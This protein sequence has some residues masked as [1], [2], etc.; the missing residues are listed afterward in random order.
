MAFEEICAYATGLLAPKMLRTLALE[1][2]GLETNPHHSSVTSD[3]D[4]HP[5]LEGDASI[6]LIGC[7]EGRRGLCLSG[8]HTVR[9]YLG[10]HGYQGASPMAV[11]MTQAAL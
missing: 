11:T 7:G 9:G 10:Y 6:S 1:S 4:P 2:L 8:A 5:L 3:K